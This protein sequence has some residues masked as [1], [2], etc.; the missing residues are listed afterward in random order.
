MAW[1]VWMSEHM[2]RTSHICEFPTISF[3]QADQFCAV[4]DVYYTHLWTD[5]RNIS[6]LETLKEAKTIAI[7][8]AI[9]AFGSEKKAGRL[10]APLNCDN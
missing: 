6:P 8:K 10:Q 2:V 7:C 9:A 1:F 4:H 5:N 3:Q